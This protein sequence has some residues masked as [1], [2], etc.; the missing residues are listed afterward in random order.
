[1]A[2]ESA[3]R[4]TDRIHRVLVVGLAS[5]V[6]VG[7]GLG[8]ITVTA[9]PS[10]PSATPALLPNAIPNVGVI[11]SAGAHPQQGTVSCTSTLPAA[12]GVA[13]TPSEIRTAYSYS[14][15]VGAGETIAIIDAYGSPSLSS[16]VACFDQVFNLPAPSLQIVQPF[17]SPHG[18]NSNWGLETSLDVEWAHAMAPSAAILL[19]VTP[20]SSLTYLVND[21]VPYA[22]SHGAKVISMSWGA[23]ESSLGCSTE[24]S[25]A[26]YF[27]NAAAAGA[28]PVASSGDSGANSGT[29]SP[30]VEYPAADPNVVGTGGTNL[31]TTSSFAW[32]HEI[33]WNDAAGA[34]GGGVSTC[35]GEPTYQ[36][37]HS[38]Q[39]TTSSGS[40]TPKGRAVPDVAYDSSPYTGFWVWDTS[41]F[42]G[43]VQVGGTSA[44]S[45]QWAAIFADAL[46]AGVTNLNGG[47]VHGLL[48]NLL[49][50]T[51]VH[52]ITSGN[53]GFYLAST[54]YDA[55]TGVGT[56]VESSVLSAL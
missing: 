34:T 2:D 18:K 4:T 12:K 30:T 27:A 53:N 41:G 35:F 9:V 7:L 33:V 29:S 46:S 1:M 28:I 31:T 50:T 17:G 47:S 52:D 32:S 16:D 20:S 55:C 13:Y 5:M 19:I 3:W 8:L 21:A 51:N 36:S 14:S 15:A 25:E 22:V 42:S 10:G 23:A 49:G 43:W 37:S 26:S 54:G 6:V 44:A 11:S 24:T 48:Y 45:P 56:P 40:S 38:I 39:V